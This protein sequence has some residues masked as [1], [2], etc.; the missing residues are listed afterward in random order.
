[1]AKVAWIGL[2]VMGYPMAGHIPKGEFC[3]V[4]HNRNGAKGR[5]VRECGGKMVATPADAAGMPTS[6]SRGKNDN[7]LREVTLGGK[8]AFNAVK[9]GAVFIDNTT[10]SANRTLGSA[11]PRPR[12]STSWMPRCPAARP[13]RSTAC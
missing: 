8:G 13:V 3:L 2:G 9:K 11:P 5:R 10:A 12:A 6:S 4:V 1:M 7:D